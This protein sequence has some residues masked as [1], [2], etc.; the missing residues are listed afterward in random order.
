MHSTSIDLIVSNNG[1]N[2]VSD[3]DKVL[4]E[5]SRIIKHGGQFLLTMNLNNTMFEFY[6]LFKNL[7]QELN[8]KAEIEKMNQQ[9]YNKRKPLEGFIEL[10]EKYGFQIKN[11][12]HNQFDYKFIDGTT[13]LNHYFIRMAFLNGWKSIIPIGKQEFI[14][15]ELERRMNNKAQVDGFFRLSVPFVVI[16]CIK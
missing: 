5:C 3:L 8:M 12:E 9:I 13:L 11:V 16:D 7:L 15:S 2:N 10:L 6:E 1:I 14:F 4:S